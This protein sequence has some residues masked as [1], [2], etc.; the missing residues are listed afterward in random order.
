[1]TT[2][3]KDPPRAKLEQLRTT[4]GDLGIQWHHRCKA[5]TLMDRI[6]AHR[7]AQKERGPEHDVMYAMPGEMRS[8]LRVC[9]RDVPN[10]GRR[11]KKYIRE[12][13]ERVANAESAS[14]TL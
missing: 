12:L 4:C 7:D 6:A 10:A 13:L 11:L 14:S 5:S 9:C 3:I 2:A 8:A 1:M